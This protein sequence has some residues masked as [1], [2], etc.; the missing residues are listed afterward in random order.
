M[1]QSECGVFLKSLELKGTDKGRV[2]APIQILKLRV[3][4]V[5]NYKFSGGTV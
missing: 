5:N 1:Y 2:E 4:V 3:A